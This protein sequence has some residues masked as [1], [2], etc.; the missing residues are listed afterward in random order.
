M[1]LVV[2]LSK[3]EMYVMDLFSSWLGAWGLVGE[4]GEAISYLITHNS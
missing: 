3:R 2:L 1:Y 4:K